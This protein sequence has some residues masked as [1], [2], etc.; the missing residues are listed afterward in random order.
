MDIIHHVLFTNL[1]PLILFITGTV[2]L[3]G[4]DE[5]TTGKFTQFRAWLIIGLFLTFALGLAWTVYQIHVK[6]WLR[7]LLLLPPQLVTL[8]AFCIH[9]GFH[10]QRQADAFIT[11]SFIDIFVGLISFLYMDIILLLLWA[12]NLLRSVTCQAP[13][14]AADQTSPTA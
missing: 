9:L 11:L 3:K 10:C 8:T 14:A 4:R 12:N 7:L 2:I 6:K 1:G 5:A 13:H